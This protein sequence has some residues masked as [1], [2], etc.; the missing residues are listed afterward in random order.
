V[1]FTFFEDID[2][3]V[4]NLESPIIYDYED[5]NYD[6][7][8]KEINLFSTYDIKFLINKLKIRVLSLANNHIFDFGVRGFVDT[9][10]F[11]KEQNICYCGAGLNFSEA[12]K[13]CIM[14]I[15][16]FKIG[17]VSFGWDL[18]QCIPALKKSPG[19]NPLKFKNIYY[20][21]EGIRNK[22]DILMSFV[23]WGY[24]F[25]IFPLPVH[26]ELARK[27]I[28]WGVDIVVGSHPHVV[29]GFEKYKN[30]FIFYSLGNFFFP[31]TYYRNN[32]VD[33]RK[34]QENMEFHLKD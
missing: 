15:D 3:S 22:V 30:R 7:L 17:I 5:Y 1:P 20:Q 6:L 27:M 25:E 33:F 28:D 8:D 13:P 2:F 11:L 12:S 18:I 31:D 9:I 34:K 23:H 14:K 16:K 4:G 24:E 32:K 10:N 21:I 29:Q 19:V 26:R